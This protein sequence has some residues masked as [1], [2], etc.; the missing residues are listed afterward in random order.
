VRDQRSS[1]LQSKR[2][3]AKQ[4]PRGLSVETHQ[5]RKPKNRADVFEAIGFAQGRDATGSPGPYVIIQLCDLAH[6]SAGSSY[7]VGGFGHESCD[8]RTGCLVDRRSIVCQE[9]HRPPR[10]VNP[11]GMRTRSL[12]ISRLA[13]A[14]RHEYK[15]TLDYCGMMGKRQVT[16][17]LPVCPYG[18]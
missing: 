7:V 12:T 2:R 18:Q 9:T 6:C 15:R 1:S 3:I 10:P 14:I 8:A 16:E 4:H 13:E 5:R 11:V 17:L